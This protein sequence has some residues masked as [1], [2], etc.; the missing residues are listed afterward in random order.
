MS[1]SNVVIIG[2]GTFEKSHN[3]HF[4]PLLGGRKEFFMDDQKIIDLYFSRDEMAIQ[5]TASKYGSLCQQ[6]SENIV[7]NT[8]DAEECVND[9]YLKAWNSIPP[10]RP[11]SLGAF[12]CKIVRRL[13]INRLKYNRRLRRN[14]EV[15]VALHELED[16]IPMPEESSKELAW[17]LE[18]FLSKQEPLD[19]KL[20]MGR[21]WHAYP[22]NMMAKAYGMTSGA[23]SAK[24]Y[25]IREKLKQYMNERGYRV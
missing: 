22:V 17:L 4:L 13:S 15:D 11:A 18:D 16:C 12:V 24:L 19:Q 14:C 5:E 9:T 23:V 2:E 10:T 1:T 6:I 3:K 21:Y 7:G 8:S 20:F 25:R